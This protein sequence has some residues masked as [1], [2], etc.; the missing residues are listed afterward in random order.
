MAKA[1]AAKYLDNTGTYQPYV[2]AQGEGTYTEPGESGLPVAAPS[3]NGGE[4][5][6]SSEPVG[7]VVAVQESMIAG[8]EMVPVY[9]V[10]QE[11]GACPTCGSSQ[12]YFSE[13]CVTCVVCGFSECG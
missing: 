9:E 2:D 8:S 5:T 6:D 7:R 1:I 4:A 12:M 3:G 10:A 11:R 13:G